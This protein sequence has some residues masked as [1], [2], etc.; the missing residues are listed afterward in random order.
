MVT[1]G[2]VFVGRQRE[3]ALLQAALEESLSGQ[4]RL[5]MLV[6]EPGIGK[7][8]TAQELAAAA[9]QRGA[10]V[11]WGRCYEQAGAP[12]YWPWVQSLR[13]YVQQRDADQL[14]SEMG[15]GA[16]DIAEIFLEVRDKL[17]GLVPPPALD[18]PEASRFRL[19]DSITTFL[20]NVAQS[21]P[22][23]LVLDDLHW[24]DQPSLLL[25]QFLARELGNAR[26][27]LL[28]AYRDVELSRHHP[29][30][31]TLAQLSR[32]PIFQR[33][34]LRGLS[35]EDTQPFIWAT[36]GI[37]SPTARADAIH[38]RTEGNPFFMAEVVRLL[39]EQGGLTE[40]EA[41]GPLGIQVPEGVR[42]AIGQRLN[43]LT[44]QCNQM[45]TTASV[46]G[47][48]F[49]FKLLRTLR[50]DQTEG[51]LL[52]AVDEAL[53]AHLID[54]LPDA[55]DRYQ[56]SHA[57]IQE[58]L[59]GE[60]STTRKVRLHARIA[61]ALEKLY[62]PQAEAHAAELT[63]HFAEAESV[64]GAEKLVKYSLLAG[65]RALAS[66]AW[67]EGSSHFQ[68]GL[69]AKGI[70]WT[71][72]EPAKDAETAALLFGLG[73]ARGATLQRRQM[74][75]A[76]NLLTRAFDYLEATGDMARAVAVAE[77]PLP[78]APIGR[79]GVPTFITRALKLV[80]PDSL[81]EGR[82]L[83]RYGAELGRLEND[84]TGAQRAFNRALAVAR[85]EKDLAL[86][87]STLVE[88]ADVD[89]S[90][91]HLPE[92]LANA[93]QAIE[94]ARGLSDPQ[95]AWFAHLDAARALWIMGDG[96]A[97][98]RH[99]SA[100]LELAEKLHDRYR[101][102][103][104]LWIN[105]NLY[106]HW[107]DWR[108]AR[109]FCD[110]GLTLAPRD[111]GILAN[112]VMLEHEVG[113]FVAGEAYVERLLETIPPV[114]DRPGSQYAFPAQVIPWVARITGVLERLKVA[115]A[116]AQTVL[117]SRFANPQYVLA[118][119]AGLGLVA[120]L[121]GDI[122]AAA[123][124]YEGLKLRRGLMLFA[125]SSDHVLGLLA[126]TVGNLDKAAEHFEDAL[127]FCRRAG[128][129]PELA[130]ACHDYAAALLQSNR[131]G[132]IQKATALLEK[133]QS[134]SGEL[135]MRPLNERVLNLQGQL[136]LRHT[137][138]QPC[139]AGLTEREVEVLAL[140]A[141]GKSN[142]E[143]ADDLALSQRTVQRHIS[144]VY[145]KIN[146]RNRAEATT[147]FLTQLLPSL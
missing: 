21:Q 63:Y 24:A 100:A 57:L 94:L 81:A 84:Y 141:K 147:F 13:S 10:H 140:V 126:H 1:T 90:Q 62:G 125:I 58:T 45:L 43:R 60:L 106:R 96:R 80:P 86:E 143:I 138:R 121:R 25:L 89:Y 87:V 14:R 98:Q 67:E 31:E 78:P 108:R 68:R 18:S 12:P 130:W 85:R 92:A 59:A 30:S 27:L 19:F 65:E 74:Q 76:V 70:P 72:T 69:A 42:D 51:Q 102:I 122:A 132:D 111:N 120:A 7:T 15:P 131:A 128:Y 104:A 101:L 3:M 16:A 52:N 41:G 61:Q 117:S 66:Y 105:A 107:G 8:R 139:P 91:L 23:V 133:A 79:T 77:Y 116:A 103:L 134:I 123:E 115:E 146:A 145:T 56:F 34:P 71:G 28:G 112:G 127:A 20:K 136:G 144:N 118:S 64:L 11:L 48:E 35:R 109:D 36:A 75:E 55:T 88:S 50:E 33:I 110:Q 9:G 26:V 137:E 129:L 113:D 47:R 5:V 2:S 44:K 53:K 4:G 32:E 95:A 114:V 93:G 99:A 54:E 97:V 37:R 38:D 46:I 40:E 142:R 119:R 82:L 49:D 6:G 29:L 22:L 135:G 124:Q 39:S 83:C 17:P 73:R